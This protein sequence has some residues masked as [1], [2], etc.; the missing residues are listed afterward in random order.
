MIV[1]MPN[2]LPRVNILL[3]ERRENARDHCWSLYPSSKCGNIGLC[4]VYHCNLSYEEREATKISRCDN[5][6]FINVIM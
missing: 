1:W 3:I 6:Q 4:H 5:M 2:I